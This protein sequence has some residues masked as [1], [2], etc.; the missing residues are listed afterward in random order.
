MEAPVGD[1]GARTKTHASVLIVTGEDFKGHKWE[2]TEPVL[3]RQI[4]ADSRLSVDVVR[5]LEQLASTDLDAYDAVVM[6][7]KNYN[8]KVPGRDSYDNLMRF[9]QAGG[10]LVLVHFACGAF[11]EYKQKNK[12]WTNLLRAKPLATGPMNVTK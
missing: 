7:F 4:L 9:V 5:D 1:A 6:H 10:G 8:P 3:R 12:N 2:Q 11:Q